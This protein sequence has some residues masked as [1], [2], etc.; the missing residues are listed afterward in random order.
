M[1][2]QAKSALELTKAVPG[3][4]VLYTTDRANRCTARA[5]KW[6]GNG[7]ETA[8]SVARTVIVNFF[9]DLYRMSHI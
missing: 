3:F 2:V 9:C 7:T 4:V 8:V 6:H 1:Y 5:R